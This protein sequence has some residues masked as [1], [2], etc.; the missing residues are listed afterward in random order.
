VAFDALLEVSRPLRTAV[1][2]AAV[3][4][5]V[6][7]QWPLW[8]VAPQRHAHALSGLSKESL[9]DRDLVSAV[10][11]HLRRALDP[12]D[13]LLLWRE[14]LG[15]YFCRLDYIPDHNNAGSS[16]IILFHRAANAHS[17]NC[18]LADMGVSDVRFNWHAAQPPL[19]VEGYGPDDWSR[20]RQRV[21]AF[22]RHWTRPELEHGG[23]LIARLH[24]AAGCEAA[25][26][27]P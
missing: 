11:R 18:S 23:L 7:C 25:P 17:L 20:D 13:R 22:V 2:A 8:N 10:G 6:L 9:E 1:L 24:P 12:D 26:P 5:L 14:P 21:D 16:V 15:Y 27:A 4:A 3:Y 19:F